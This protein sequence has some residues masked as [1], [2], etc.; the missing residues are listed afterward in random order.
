VVAN[1]SAAAFQVANAMSNSRGASTKI[2]HGVPITRAGYLDARR[3]LAV[4]AAKILKP[5]TMTISCEID[6]IENQHIALVRA[7][8]LNDVPTVQVLSIM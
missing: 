3:K 4:K 6:I 2:E 8:D 5:F 7:I 1:A